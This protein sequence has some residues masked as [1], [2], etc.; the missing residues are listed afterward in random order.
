MEAFLKNTSKE[1]GFNVGDSWP[2]QQSHSHS[3][4]MQ[5]VLR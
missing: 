5:L 2:M 1:D 4:Y 3:M